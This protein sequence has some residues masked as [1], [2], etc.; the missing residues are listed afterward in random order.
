MCYSA[1]P[2]TTFCL[3]WV[4]NLDVAELVSLWCQVSIEWSALPSGASFSAVMLANSI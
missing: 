4:K 2:F 3:F 1:H